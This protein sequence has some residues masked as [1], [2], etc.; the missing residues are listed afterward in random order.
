MKSFGSF[1]GIVQKIDN[2]VATIEF[3]EQ[4]V[5]LGIEDIE[6]LNEMILKN[7]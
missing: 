6:N 5:D 1:N 4:I 3:K 2:D 7:F